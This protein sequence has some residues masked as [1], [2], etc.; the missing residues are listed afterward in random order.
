MNLYEV[1]TRYERAGKKGLNT[2]VQEQYL[3]LA[4]NCAASENITTL[5]L[6]PLVTGGFKVTC[7]KQSP[8]KGIIR[9]KNANIS[10]L[11]GEAEQLSGNKAANTD[12]DRFY[13]CKVN[14]I[15]VYPDTLKEKKTSVQYIVNAGTIDAAKKLLTQFLG[16]D[17]YEIASIIETKI[18]DYLYD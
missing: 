9:D 12:A 10:Q 6:A 2:T 14:M 1:S 7:I 15:T 11:T 13:R 4:T 16:A 5:S 17:D 8:A 18:I 3:V